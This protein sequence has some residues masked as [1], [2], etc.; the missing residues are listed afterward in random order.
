MISNKLT[1]LPIFILSTNQ[2]D[3]SNDPWSK[4]DKINNFIEEVWNWEY[5]LRMGLKFDP[6]TGK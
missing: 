3:I 1:K 2:L 6:F 5:Y 4:I